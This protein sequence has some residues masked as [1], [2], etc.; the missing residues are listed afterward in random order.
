MTNLVPYAQVM[1]RILE[2]ADKLNPQYFDQV[3][4]R[5]KCIKDE[6][7]FKLKQLELMIGHI[8]EL[9]HGYPEGIFE[10]ISSQ[11]N[12][13]RITGKDLNIILNEE[14]SSTIRFTNTLDNLL[15]EI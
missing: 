1:E 5:M 14:V 2:F 11:K 7:D 15:S 10:L 9:P 8:H 4:K 6:L 3:S 12:S 13:Q